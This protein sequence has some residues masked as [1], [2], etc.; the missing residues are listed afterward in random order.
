M[1]DIISEKIAQKS[2]SGLTPT[3]PVIVW[4]S[5]A[6]WSEIE[7]S[8]LMKKLRVMGSLQIPI[9]EP[10]DV[11]VILALAHGGHSAAQLNET[12]NSVFQP[13]Q[14][15]A[16]G[17]ASYQ[18]SHKRVVSMHHIGGHAGVRSAD[19][20]DGTPGSTA[21]NFPFDFE[22][23]L[24]SKGYVFDSREMFDIWALSV[25]PGD[26]GSSAMNMAFR[27]KGV[28]LND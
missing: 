17:R 26:H 18:A 6:E 24:P 2:L 28:I 1:V 8:Y 15:K 3:V 25:N 21:T 7:N 20:I 23:E 13:L 10:E 19:D 22:F 9:G 5:S 27:S 16:S 4:D 11:D 14:A 12:L